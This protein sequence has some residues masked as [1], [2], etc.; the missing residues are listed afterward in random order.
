MSSK[1][2]RRIRFIYDQFDL[3][4]KKRTD[5]IS[6]H[7]SNIGSEILLGSD[8]VE[9]FAILHFP[10]Q[11]SEDLFDLTGM[12]ISLTEW[13]IEGTLRPYLTMETK[14]DF[15]YMFSSFIDDLSRDDLRFPEVALKKTIS[16]WRGVWSRAA[17]PLDKNAQKGLMGELI[18]LDQIT[19]LG[20]DYPVEFWTGPD[21]ETHDF[22]FPTLHME[23]KTT[24]SHPPIV[25]ISSARQ[26]YTIHGKKLFLIIVQLEEGA[27]TS[28]PE[29]VKLVSKNLPNDDSR[30]NLMKKLEKIG[31]FAEDSDIYFTKYAT[32]RLSSLEITDQ[33][34]VISREVGEKIPSNV[35]DLEYVLDLT[36]ISLEDFNSEK[37]GSYFPI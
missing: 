10:G 31:F 23:V 33:S 28:L 7:P 13:K 22:C 1:Q 14:S 27:G 29:M 25:H 11:L 24:T 21:G 17:I 20:I 36:G 37:L 9:D 4:S 34:P 35:I 8:G 15:R 5:D 30:E 12:K 18:I 19:H 26:L 2:L 32:T 16:K 6:F 3:S